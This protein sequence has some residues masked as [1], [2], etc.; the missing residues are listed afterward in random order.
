L[1]G[2]HPKAPGSAGGY[3]L[4]PEQ[5]A[6]AQ[7]LGREARA[8]TPGE[9]RL[10]PAVPANVVTATAADPNQLSDDSH[11]SP[12][13]SLWNVQLQGIA[14]YINAHLYTEARD[15]LRALVQKNEFDPGLRFVL[16]EVLSRM[17]D[18]VLASRSFEA[19]RQLDQGFWQ[20]QER[21][22]DVQLHV[23]ETRNL[24]ARLAASRLYDILSK[25]QERSPSASA[26]YAISL[27]GV[28]NDL[29]DGRLRASKQLELLMSPVGVWTTDDNR[30]FK[31]T[32]SSNRWW[33]GS[34]GQAK[35]GWHV[36]FDAIPSPK[37]MGG[38]YTVDRTCQ[39]GVSAEANLLDF[40]TRIE[41]DGYLTGESI[42]SFSYRSRSA[43]DLRSMNRTC[44]EMNAGMKARL[45]G[46]PM[47]HISLRRLQ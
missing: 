47:Y 35:Y 5:I 8:T 37:M 21:E 10:N 27:L 40:A 25:A 36:S 15:Q 45:N 38:G 18:Y 1:S 14:R 42:V 46:K 11:V 13:R 22:A 7:R 2:S 39:T 9:Q 32:F 16:G 44:Q 29:R 30:V 33:L 24:E 17:Q 12:P 3:L 4:T 20:A 43:A 19:A 28:A 23:W 31:V 34:D 26:L 41:V 6:E